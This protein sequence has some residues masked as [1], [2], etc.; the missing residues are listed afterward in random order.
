LSKILTIDQKNALDEIKK[1]MEQPII[2]DRLLCGDV[3]FGKTEVAFRAAFKAI[4]SGKQVALLCPTTLLARQHY[5]TAQERFK[6]FGVRIAMLSRMVSEKEQNV[7]LKKLKN[8]EIDFI[9]GT[10]RLLSNDIQFNDLG[11]LI[12]DEEHKFGVEHKEKIKEFKSNVDVLT[13]SATP[14]PRTLQMALTGVRGFSTITTPID[15]RM[16]V[17]TYVLEKNDYAIK[18]IIERN[19]II[20][21]VKTINKDRY[22]QVGKNMYKIELPANM[23]DGMLIGI[24]IDKSKAGK[25]FHATLDKVIGHKNATGIEEQKILYEQGIPFTFDANTLKEAY[26]LP[27]S[28]KEEDLELIDI[29][30]GS[31]RRNDYPNGDVVINNTAL[32]CIK[33][34][35]GE[36]K[37]DSE[38]K[39]MKFFDI[40]KLPK[41]QNDPDLIEIY[42]KKDKK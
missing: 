33:K 23:V 26:N 6:N 21:E 15:N 34:Y 39:N 24:K 41:N 29:V 5:L 17:Q 2:M 3:G 25:Y 20:A 19:G 28:V 31:S 13:L 37:W 12:V 4:N 9:V 42:I 16:P 35:S 32:Y 38:S 11:L 1:D 8:K 7:I 30:S 27:S 22:A 36:L 18:E 10:H 14:I 40:D